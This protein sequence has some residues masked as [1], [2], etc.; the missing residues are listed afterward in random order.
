MA[1][2]NTPREYG[3][4]TKLFHW[5]IVVLFVFQYFSAHAMLEHFGKGAV[6]GVGTGYFFSWHKS[7]GLV[8][9]AIILARIVNRTLDALPAWAAG[10]TEREKKFVHGYEMLLYAGMLVMP[11]SGYVYVMAADYGVHFFE[12]VKLSNPIGKIP[13]LAVAAKWIHIVSGW[14]ILAAIVAHLVVV[15]RHQLLLRD[16][17]MARMWFR[18]RKRDGAEWG[19]SSRA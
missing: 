19:E 13:V 15:L 3:I 17:L 11:I 18:G 4:L 14:V 5:S 9:L 7:I 8:A 10:L 2:L 6:L 16:K 1:I 12:L